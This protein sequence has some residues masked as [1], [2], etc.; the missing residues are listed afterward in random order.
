VRICVYT[1]VILFALLS[2]SLDA[3]TAKV[4]SAR[5]FDDPTASAALR[6]MLEKNGY[7]VLLPNGSPECEI[8]FRKSIPIEAKPA[9]EGAVYRFTESELIGVIR[10]PKATVDFRG[11]QLKAGIYTMRYELSPNDGNHLGVSATRDFVL[12]LPLGVDKNPQATYNLDEL[13]VLSARASGTQHAAPMA[14]ISPAENSTP[15]LTRTSEG[16]LLFSVKLKAKSGDNIPFAMVVEGS[17]P[18]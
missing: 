16:W 8:W 14:L 10:F 6:D 4:E 12:L 18:Q 15:S 13:V 17:S 3:A 1:S 11:Q 5:S 2:G 9:A 7:R